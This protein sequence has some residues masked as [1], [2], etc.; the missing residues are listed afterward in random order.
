MS[1]LILYVKTGC[2]WCQKVLDFAS[3]KGIEFELRNIKDVGVVDELIARGGKRQVPYLVDQNNGTEMYE[4]ADII[5]YL[6][7]RLT[8]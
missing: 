5:E 1:D 6:R 3:E 7:K 2:P 8:E 4:S